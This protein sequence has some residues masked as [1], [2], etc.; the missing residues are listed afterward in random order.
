MY[1]ELCLYV[2]EH[3]TSQREKR[4]NKL[5]MSLFFN[6]S[7]RKAEQIFEDLFVRPL[8]IIYKTKNSMLFTNAFQIHK[9]N[10]GSKLHLLKQFL[11]KE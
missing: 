4:M 11:I 6:F 8:L 9:F 2:V 1:K 7:S 5:I 3:V 10:N